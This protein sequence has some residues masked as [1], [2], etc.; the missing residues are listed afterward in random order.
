MAEQVSVRGVD[1]KIRN[2]WL[3]F[4]WAIVTLGI[5]Y[6]V[7]YYKVNRELRD[8]GRATGTPELG[9][10]P[11]TSLLAI[12]LGW[13]IVIPP[14]VSVYRTFGRI[15]TAQHVA[16]VGR[17]ANSVLG[18]V[19]FFVALIFLPVEL[20]YAQIELNEVWRREREAPA[21]GAGD[22]APPEAPTS[23]AELPSEPAA[24]TPPETP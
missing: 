13:L 21:G 17:E 6:L 3:V 10:S 18:L 5:Y 19:L 12:T 20:P 2:P 23:Q 4:L 14:F 1:V 8:Y 15:A 22:A 16:G 24:E 7:W 9:D 11:L